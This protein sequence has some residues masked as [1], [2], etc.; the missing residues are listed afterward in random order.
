MNYN[1]FFDKRPHHEPP[2]GVGS[3]GE[4]EINTEKGKILLVNLDGGLRL[5]LIDLLLSDYSVVISASEEEALALSK[6]I[7]PDLIV[8]GGGDERLSSSGLLCKG[9]GVKEIFHIP[10]LMLSEKVD[11]EG[12]TI[13]FE[14]TVNGQS[15]LYSCFRSFSYFVSD[16]MSRFKA[17]SFLEAIGIYS[18][19][20]HLD[21]KGE[22]WLDRCISFVQRNYHRSEIST[23]ELASNVFLSERQFL[24]KFTRIMS[25]TPTYFINEYRLYIA[26]NMLRSGCR[27]SEVADRVGFNSVQ[28]L[29]RMY[30]NKYG[31]PPSKE[32]LLQ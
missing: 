29:S 31:L 16:F 18:S 7:M 5:K 19:L 25:I 6:E 3:Y 10:V 17:S 26:R 9:A 14:C 8:A 27:V 24:R 20:S 2:S 23:K 1:D 11:D 28:Y 21:G 13:G 30:K 32:G 22:Q 4:T 12:H 15:S